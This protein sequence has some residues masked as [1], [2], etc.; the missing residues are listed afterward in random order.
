MPF[1]VVFPGQ[2]TQKP[3]MGLPWRQ[4]PAWGIVEEAEESLGERLSHLL[5]DAPR[6]ALARTRDAQLAVLLASLLSWRALSDRLPR[7]IAFAGHSL[8]QLSALIASG[9]LSLAD[10]IRVAARRAELTQRCAVRRPGRMVALLGAEPAQA[11]TACAAAPGCWVANDNAPG[12]VVLAGTPEGI[13]RAADAAKTLGAKRVVPI[14]VDGAFHT[15]LMAEAAAGLREELASV[16]LSDPSAP[17]VSNDDG[18]AY[19]H[20]DGWDERLAAHVVSRV[21]WRDTQHTLVAMGAARFVEAGPG[22]VLANLARRT[23]PGT[24]VTGVS[25]PDDLHALDGFSGGSGPDGGRGEPAAR[26]GAMR[27]ERER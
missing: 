5:L 6:G 23:V 26:A 27:W 17:V 1:A 11:E 16:P 7:P 20:R 13:E 12:Q 2:G 3:A 24:P 18:V 19:R 22:S 25:S 15:P 8:G 10:G 4:H 21:R 9:A 14:D